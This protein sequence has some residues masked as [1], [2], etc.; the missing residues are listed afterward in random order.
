VLGDAIL[1]VY[2]YGSATAGGLR[3]QSDVD[4]FAVSARPMAT[5]ERAALSRRLGPL[6]ARRLRPPAWRPAEVSVVVASEVRPWRDAPPMDFQLGEWM[7]AD[8]DA[9]RLPPRI[10]ANPDLAVLITM[11]RST[12]RLL[13]GEP[14]AALLDVVPRDAVARGMVEGIGSLLADLESDTRNVLLTLARIWTTLA[15]GE[16]RSKDAAADWAIAQLPASDGA[17]LARARDA[18]IEGAKE[19]WAEELDGVGRLA[20]TITARTRDLVR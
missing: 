10:D 5:P 19:S 7:R 11:V 12:G 9:G 14:A 8:L 16:I 20:A 6:S 18:Y 15:T 13:R 3:P 2:L 1:G 17:L 4:I